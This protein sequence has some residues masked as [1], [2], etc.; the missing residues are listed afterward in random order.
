MKNGPR[1]EGELY[2]PLPDGTVFT[3]E[4]K[5]GIYVE[6]DRAIVRKRGSAPQGGKRLWVA[7]RAFVFDK[8]PS[9]VEA[10][11][12]AVE[13]RDEVWARH[14]LWTEEHGDR[15][16]LPRSRLPKQRGTTYYNRRLGC[17]AEFNGQLWG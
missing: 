3:H 15:S 1:K 7:Y 17:V 12:A 2:A 5:T 10:M 16:V 11:E 6:F 13:F 4:N 8:F 14:K 9:A